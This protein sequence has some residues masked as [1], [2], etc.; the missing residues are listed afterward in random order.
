MPKMGKPLYKFIRQVWFL[1]PEIILRF[2]FSTVFLGFTLMQMM[3]FFL[4]AQA[5]THYSHSTNN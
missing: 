5:G 3:F 4:A 2:I 1:D